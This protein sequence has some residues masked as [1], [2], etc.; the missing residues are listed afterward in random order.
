MISE[1]LG[2]LLACLDQHLRIKSE[3]YYG[4]FFGIVGLKSL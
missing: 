4:V 3:N 2:R 1:K